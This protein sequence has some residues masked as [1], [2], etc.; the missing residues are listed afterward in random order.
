VSDD[1]HLHIVVL[2]AGAS[3][4]LGQ[5]KQVVQIAGRPALQRVVSNAIAVA[6]SAVTVVL[7]AQ[8]AEITRMLQHSSAS[9]LINRQWEEGISASIR[10]GINSLSPGCDAVL[11]LLGD[12]V[13]VTASD[14]KRLIAAWNGQDTVLAASVYSG[15]LGVPA[16]FPRWCF[17]ELMQLHGDQGAKAIITRHGSRLIHVPMPNAAYDLDTPDDV[18][19]MQEAFK[20]RSKETLL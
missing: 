16:I 8:A 11:L 1:A 18:T 15:Q 19:A 6:G 3:T 10:C 7:G 14:L 20:N 5:P 2:A 4:R 13:A 17:T 12:Q 9:V